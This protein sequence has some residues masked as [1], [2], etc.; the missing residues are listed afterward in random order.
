MSKQRLS[1]D[2]KPAEIFRLELSNDELNYISN[3]LPAGYSFV[4][5]PK[6]SIPKHVIEAARRKANSYQN[7]DSNS[8]TIN[9][10]KNLPAQNNKKVGSTHI[11]RASHN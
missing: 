6:K 2:F 8:H 11:S 1:R 5:E 7:E 10:S 9:Q 3:R 4:L